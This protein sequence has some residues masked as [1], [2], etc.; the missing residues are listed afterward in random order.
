MKTMMSVLA[1]SLAFGAGVAEAKPHGG[2]GDH[3]GFGGIVF[4]IADIDNDGFITQ[5]ELTS[6]AQDRFTTAD[7]NGD[8]FLDADELSA[9]ANR[10]NDRTE[11]IDP[12]RLERME[13]RRA[14]MLERI[15][16]R[17][18]ENDDGMLSFE[19]LE[20]ARPGDIFDKIDADGDGKLSEVEFHEGT[21]HRDD[22]RDD[23]RDRRDRH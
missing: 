23:R 1:L 3:G 2:R 7:T 13:E 16:E 10:E 21:H 19:E 22:R 4:G 15:L 9:R 20:A 14:K 11:E 17:T 18:D 5:D 8:G 12:E 6:L